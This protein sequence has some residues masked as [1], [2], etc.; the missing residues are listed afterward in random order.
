MIV[1]ELPY[2]CDLTMTTFRDAES[3]MTLPAYLLF[4][5]AEEERS[6]VKDVLS[7][8][9]HREIRVVWVPWLPLDAWFIMG[10]TG[11]IGSPGV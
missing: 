4:L 6:N 1:E 10:Q 8:C 11:A 2:R 3:R 7:E 9:D 5:S